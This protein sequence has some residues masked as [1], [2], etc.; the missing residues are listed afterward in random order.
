MHR[1]YAIGNIIILQN[2]IFIIQLIYVNERLYFIDKWTINSKNCDRPKFDKLHLK[3]KSGVALAVVTSG[4]CQA[5][6]D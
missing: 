1:A 3:A 4:V 6:I 2:V 5:S